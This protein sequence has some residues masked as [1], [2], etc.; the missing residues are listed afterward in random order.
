MSTYTAAGFEFTSTAK[1]EPTHAVLI[2]RNGDR[3]IYSKHSSLT[4]AQKSK[5]DRERPY[6]IAADA[7]EIVPVQKIS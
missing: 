6:Y 1:R 7:I 5:K 4:G 3:G 2:T